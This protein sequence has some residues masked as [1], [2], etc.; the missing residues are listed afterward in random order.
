MS[1]GKEVVLDSQIVAEIFK[2]GVIELSSIIRDDNP[3]NSELVNN[4]LPDKALDFCLCD[5]SKG[6]CLDP[7][8]KVI[9]CNK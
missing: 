8:G 5:P 7:L 1:R 4:V 6:F 3:R 9:N 2:F